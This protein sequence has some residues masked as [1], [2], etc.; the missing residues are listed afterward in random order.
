MTDLYAYSFE[1]PL[2]MEEI[3]SRLREK[4]TWRWIE[5]DNDSWGEYISARVLDDPH[6]GMVKL[7]E[8]DGRYI[9]NVY[10]RSKDASASSE[11][12]H[13]R[14]VVMQQVLPAIGA[15]DIRETADIES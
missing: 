2:F 10:L 4:T 1:S 14:E 11:F 8:E 9:I 5:R 12:A 7:I 3:L 6:D 13:V 15:S